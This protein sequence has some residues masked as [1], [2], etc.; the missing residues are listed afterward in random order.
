MMSESVVPPWRQPREA[1]PWLCA[2]FGIRV[3]R[4]QSR[5]SEEL[6]GVVTVLGDRGTDCMAA[7]NTGA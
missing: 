4:G 7:C 2:I 1:G 5:R 3:G 6:L